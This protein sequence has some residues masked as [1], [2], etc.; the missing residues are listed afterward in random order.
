LVLLA[1]RTLHLTTGV[2]RRHEG[3]AAVGELGHI[4]FD[5]GVTVVARLRGRAIGLNVCAA[6]GFERAVIAATRSL[7]RTTLHLALILR[8]RSTGARKSEDEGQVQ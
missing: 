4:C 5:A 3:F 1:A 7:H 2:T 8:K 6:R